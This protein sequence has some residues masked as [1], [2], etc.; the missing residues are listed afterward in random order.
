MK[1]N[2]SLMSIIIFIVMFG[3]ISATMALG[4]WITESTKEP[5]KYTSGE[6]EGEYNPDDIRGSYTFAE[7]STLFKI[8][9]EVLMEG[10]GLDKDTNPEDVKSKDLEVMYEGLTVDIGNGSVKTFVALYNNLPFEL[11]DDYLPKEAVALIQEHNKSLTDEQKTYLQTHSVDLKA[12][13]TTLASNTEDSTIEEAETT[14]EEIELV[15]GST[16]FQQVLDAGVTKDQIM[17]IINSDQ[18]PPTNQVI[19]DYCNAN[20]LSFSTVKNAFNEI[21]N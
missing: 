9:P 1:I 8:D 11:G 5:I 16:T 20:G 4:T 15:N 18:V 21:G 6:N 10:F 12:A 3:G 14:A 17:Q 13:D 7:I 2:R 19:K